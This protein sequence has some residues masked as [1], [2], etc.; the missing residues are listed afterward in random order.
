[1]HE[2]YDALFV[3]HAEVGDGTTTLYVDG[4]ID[5]S[6]RAQFARALDRAIA[7]GNPEIVVDMGGVRYLDSS[8]CHCLLTARDRAADRAVCLRIGT[9]SRRSARVLEMLGLTEYL[10]GRSEPVV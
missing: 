6:V 10:V 4:E 9:Q 3:T 8:A 2:S 5:C 1:M 7:S